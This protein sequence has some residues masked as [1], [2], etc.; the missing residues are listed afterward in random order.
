MKNSK[1]Y[2]AYLSGLLLAFLFLLTFNMKAQD[3]NSAPNKSITVYQ[4]RHVPDANIEEFLKRETTYWSKV[5]QNAIDNK[6]M[7][8][9]GIFEKVGG[10]DLD[11][12]SNYLFVNTFPNIDAANEIW[13][14]SENIGGVPMDKMETG[15]LSTTT[16]QIFLHDEG[17]AQAKNADPSKDFNYVVMNYHNTSARDSF[18]NLEIK[19]WKP[20]IQTA[21]DKNQTT[22]KGWGNAVVL[23]PN[24]DDVKFNCLSYDLFPSLQEALMT[25]WDPKVVFPNKGLTMLNKISTHQPSTIVYRIVKVLN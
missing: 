12:K 15:S 10:V 7:S 24:G 13:G 11:N 21:M 3:M 23:S 19:Y 17:W 22:Q 14:S 1:N 9:W 20:F 16:A 2:F 6:K 5:A 18:I 4:Y 8:F 25:T